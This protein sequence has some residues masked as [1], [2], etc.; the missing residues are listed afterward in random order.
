MT[1]TMTPEGKI[2]TILKKI[3][4]ALTIT[5]SDGLVSVD[6]KELE[7]LIS[8][9]DHEQIFEK[10]VKDYKILKIQKKPDY[11]KE[12]KYKFKI[13]NA[14]EFRKVLNDAHIKHFGSLEMLVGDNFLAVVDVAGDI[15]N[16]LQMTTGNKVTIP[17]IPSMIR[18]P[19][20]LPAKAPNLIDRY[21]KFR[22]NAFEYL[23]NNKAIINAKLHRDEIYPLESPVEVNLDRIK[24]TKFYEKLLKVY[25]KRVKFDSGDKNNKNLQ[26]SLDFTDTASRKAWEK[27]WDTLQAI[28]TNYES[29]NKPEKLLV[30]IER[31]TI[32]NRTVFEI[33]G[34]LN[35][36]KNEGCFDW[37][38]GTKNY[39]IK[40]I[41]HNQFTET[42]K[43]TELIYNKFAK[44]YQEKTGDKI[45]NPNQ[46]TIQKIEIT[47]LPPLEFKDPKEKQSFRKISLK[48]VQI[49]YDDD[50]GV[51]KIGRQNVPLPPYK[52]EYYFCQVMFEYKPKEP[53]S[54]DIIYD[55]MTGHSTVSGGKK[56]EPIRENW[57]K[58]N[59]TMKRVNNRIK[60]IVNTDD[61]LFS[62][63][64]KTVIRNY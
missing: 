59:D 49:S 5:P 2:W 36:L 44:I 37:H 30:P 32:K 8:R 60:K 20:L 41:N 21:W 64:E 50:T 26:D 6:A 63:S 27:K 57:Q 55:K 62:W 31:L 3:D 61:N 40:N 48:S 24:F 16:E 9:E 53:V 39:E 54:W 43:K 46:Q 17:I 4:D 58:V 1:I 33:D 29:S 35:G 18:F 11:K 23:A 12:F 25:H 10:L 34:I 13:T 19:T 7:K 38:R 45:I 15:M 56:P 52:N 28:W 14:E 51:I 47:G 42:Y 22:W